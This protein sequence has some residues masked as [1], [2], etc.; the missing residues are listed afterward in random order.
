MVCASVLFLLPLQSDLAD[1]LFFSFRFFFGA[2]ADGVYFCEKL[3]LRHF[4]SRAGVGVF[5]A[6]E[7]LVGRFVFAASSDR[8]TSTSDKYEQYK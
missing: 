1:F 7:E 8:V 4:G 6:A 5:G 2:P 3:L